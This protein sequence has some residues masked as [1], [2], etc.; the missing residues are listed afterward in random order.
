MATGEMKKS[1][2]Q[3]FNLQRVVRE[4]IRLFM[5]DMNFSLPAVV[6][7]VHPDKQTVDVRPTIMKRN[8][9]TK[10][11]YQ[12]ALLLNVP[13]QFPRGGDSYVTLPIKPGDEGVLIFA[14]RDIRAWKELGG[15]QPIRSDRI[16]D[17]NDA[18]FIPGI[19][20]IPNAVPGYDPDNI[21]IVKNGK[22]ITVKDGTLEAPEYDFICK[23]INASG[24]VVVG[25]T[26]TATGA[27]SSA[28]DVMAGGISAKNH[29]HA[30]QYSSTSKTGIPE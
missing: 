15:A 9:L 10:Q 11:N 5:L 7:A 16:L 14:G 22:K 1:V 8:Q 3:Q 23:N 19:S 13:F 26:I 18:L 17:Y 27:I 20:A 2:G 28:T 21:T 25:Q 6:E 12:R 29:V 24:T 4:F 30:G